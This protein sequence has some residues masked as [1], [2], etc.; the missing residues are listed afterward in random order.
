MTRRLLTTILGAGVCTLALT[1]MLTAQSAPTRSGAATKPKA[2]PR[3]TWGDPDIGG[4]WSSEDMRSVPR[5]RPAELGTRQW[6][7]E[8]EAAQRIKQ[9][10]QMAISELNKGSFAFDFPKR[11]IRLTS[12]V[13]DPPDGRTPAV[14]A[15][16]RTRGRRVPGS[17]GA[18][19]FDS[20]LDFN[21]FERCI[22]RGVVNS[23]MPTA[24]GN[25]VTVVQSPD[26]VAITMEMIHD[27]RIIPLDGK[28]RPSPTVQKY[29]GSSSGRWEGE[30]LVIESSNF[31]D[32][33]ALGG[34]TH[35]DALVLT[36]RIWRD[37]AFTLNYQVTVNDPET[38]EKPY[39][40]MLQLTQPEDGSEHLVLPYEC[41]EGNHGLRNI[42]SAERAE[43]A[44][45]AA[46]LANGVNR[47]RR[48][49]NEGSCNGQP[50]AQPPAGGGRGG[51]GRGAGGAPP[52]PRDGGPA[53]GGTP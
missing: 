18:G 35:S 53:R 6:L 3:T 38:Y 36:E 20:W 10:Q 42:L 41:H 44:A 11:V 49:A 33:T 1:S 15:A 52:G 21:L 50:C 25:S 4:V 2:V 39:T 31:R 45:L 7:T 17:M 19:P 37:D 47:P 32:G 43:D 26:S 48:M 24:Y 9:N 46:D 13:I 14:L 8:E 34:V 51:G 5:D 29:M 27:T 12:I 30:K 40:M 22:T 28:K 23:I 16:A